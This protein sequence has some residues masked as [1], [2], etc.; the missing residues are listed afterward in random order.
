SA[1]GAA[2]ATVT[3]RLAATR[4][5]RSF[6]SP[7]SR[8]DRTETWN[9]KLSLQRFLPALEK[10]EALGFVQR[11]QQIGADLDGSQHFAHLL[12]QR[13]RRRLP[14][15]VVAQRIDERLVRHDRLRAL[16]ENIVEK[17]LSGVRMAR[18]LGD[19]GDAREDERVIL[20]KHEADRLVF[21]L[22]QQAVRAD[23]V[24]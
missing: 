8:S 24:I 12:G 3:P 6:T 19:E 2:T 7:R 20:G 21:L 22:A 14:L 13:R 18:A 17:E 1:S 23:D 9:L 10:I 5:I 11:R 15:H 4:D 16:G